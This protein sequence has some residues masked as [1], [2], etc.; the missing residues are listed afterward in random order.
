MPKIFINFRNGDSDWAAELLG[1][2]LAQPL[3][4]EGSIFKSN[5]SIPLGE[6]WPNHLREAARACD[7]LLALVGPAWLTITGEDGRPRIFDDDDWVRREISTALAAG[8]IVAAIRLGNT[9]WLSPED[10]PEDIRELANRQGWRLDR[11]Q[12]ST[13]YAGLERELMEV[14]PGLKPK[15]SGARTR[16][17]SNLEVGE[18]DGHVDIVHIPEEEA[19]D[20]KARTKIDRMGPDSSYTVLRVDA[21]MEE[22]R[23][24]GKGDRG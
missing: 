1:E 8:R 2:K 22:E 11:R 15:L 4:G 5:K 16:V 14:V 9:P 13:D 12:F 3:T 7:V 20:I 23:D 24:R 10:L 18:M 17:N 21:L 19:L 6:P